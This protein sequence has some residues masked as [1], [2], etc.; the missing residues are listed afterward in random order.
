MDPQTSLFSF[1]NLTS[2]S[3]IVRHGLAG[4][5]KSPRYR[6]RTLFFLPL[7]TELFPA[8]EEIPPRFWD[9]LLNHCPDLHELAICSFSSSSRVFNFGRV[10]QGRWPKLHTLTLGS[11]G[12]QSD[13]SLGPPG[14]IEDD[15][16]NEDD[17]NNHSDSKNPVLTLGQF[18]DLHSELKYIRFLW[19]FKRWMSPNLIPLSF[20]STTSTSLPNLDTFIGIYQQLINIPHPEKVETLD[21][22]CE[23]VYENRL[24]VVVPI[25][26]KLTGLTSLDIWMHMV[27]VTSGRGWGD[28][29]MG[30]FRTVLEACP[31]LVDFHF[32]CTTSFT[33]VCPSPPICL[34][35]PNLTRFLGSFNPPNRQPLSPPAS[36][37]ILIDQRTQIRR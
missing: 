5:G 32:M 26:K 29:Q 7:F 19:N 13:F 20:S 30:F 4:S 6:P 34:P 23:P 14:L 25:L 8:L 15:D 3:L 10:T 28:N 37:T 2:F 31:G 22:T 27:D 16:A 21:L 33:A 18:L 24:T 17:T 1:S 9:M 35:S 11:F 36:K 12:Y